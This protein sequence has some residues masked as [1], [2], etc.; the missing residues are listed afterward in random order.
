MTA[1][2]ALNPEVPSSKITS[3]DSFDSRVFNDLNAFPD[4]I[5]RAFE[6]N[7]LTWYAQES[8]LEGE[9][10][11]VAAAGMRSIL[12]GGEWS[13]TVAY[14]EPASVTGPKV[15][16]FLNAFIF[17]QFVQNQAVSNS[18]EAVLMQY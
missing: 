6:H 18:P 5:Q 9:K 16:K 2:K 13:K 4:S 14:S 1:I 8:T 11:A 7:I 3:W 10:S 12:M 17:M 15:K